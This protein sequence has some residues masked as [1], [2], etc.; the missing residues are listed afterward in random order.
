MDQLLNRVVSFG[1]AYPSKDDGWHIRGLHGSDNRHGGHG[2]EEDYQQ[3]KVDYQK[4][5]TCKKSQHNQKV[6]HKQLLL[7]FRKCSTDCFSLFFF[8]RKDMWYCLITF[9]DVSSIV[10]YEET[11]GHSLKHEKKCLTPGTVKNIHR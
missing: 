11:N 2:R 5:Q 8:K 10:L 1:L 3:S 7:K 6:Q 4:P 9:D